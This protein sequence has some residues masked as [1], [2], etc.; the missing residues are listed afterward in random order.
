MRLFS[1]S[2]DECEEN[3]QNI[4]TSIDGTV[5]QKIQQV[6]GPGRSPLHTIFRE[7]SWPTGY[8][9]RNIM[10]GKVRSAFSLILDHRIMNHVKMCTESEGGRVLGSEWS[11]TS[12]DSTTISER[13]KTYQIGYCKKNHKHLF[14]MFVKNVYGR[15]FPSVKSATTNKFYFNLN[16]DI[17]VNY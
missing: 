2:E 16:N 4:E 17:Y 9:K 13:R 1:S 7:I 6:S 8:A 14:Y 3:D 5:W 15:D 10:K 11:L 12:V